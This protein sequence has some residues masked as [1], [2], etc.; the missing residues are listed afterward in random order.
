M[1][2]SYV[3]DVYRHQLPVARPMDTA[4]YLAF[5]PHLVAGPIV[6]GSELLPQI[7]RKRDPANVDYSR[8]I[9]M[10]TAGLFKKVVVSSYVSTAIVTPVFT[11]PGAHSGLEAVFAAWGY[12]VQIYCDFSGYTDIAIGLALLL[13]FRFPVNFDAPVHRA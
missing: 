9:W 2:L 7:R 3:I 13:G 11:A 6:R 10:I 12:A 1:A 5:F 8:A 4:V